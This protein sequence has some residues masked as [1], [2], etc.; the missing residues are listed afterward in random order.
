MDKIKKQL[1]S[2]FTL[3]EMITSLAV[4]MFIT[5]LFIANYQAANKRTD[6]IMTAQKMVG[7]IHLAENNC[8]GLVKYDNYVP[9][10]GWGVHFDKDANYYM[11]FAETSQPSDPDYLDFSVQGQDINYGA[12]RSEFAVNTVIEDILLD[13]TSVTEANVI[14]LPPD[15]RVNINDGFATGTALQIILKETAN[16]STKTIEVN[17]LGLAEV[18]D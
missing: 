10:G 18:I 2:G 17:F 11:V 16:N 6:I 1:R 14:F 13:G 3:I 4:I 8:L 5:V 15:P 7:D 9:A 12:R